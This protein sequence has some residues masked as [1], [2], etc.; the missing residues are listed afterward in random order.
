MLTTLKRKQSDL[1]S[2]SINLLA[3][4]LTNTETA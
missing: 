2:S 1:Y 4:E 3:I